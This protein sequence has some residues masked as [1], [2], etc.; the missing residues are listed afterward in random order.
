MS[1][2]KS[3]KGK[4]VNEATAQTIEPTPSL[5]AGNREDEI[6]DPKDFIYL[7]TFDE[8][9]VGKRFLFSS[10]VAFFFFC[11]IKFFHSFIL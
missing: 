6:K 5:Q 11:Y 3:E 1:L 7:D 4:A 10:L 8:D 9:E 2:S